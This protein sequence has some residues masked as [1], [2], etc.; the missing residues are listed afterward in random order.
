[1]I[2]TD[3]RLQRSNTALSS[4]ESSATFPP[5]CPIAHGDAELSALFCTL[6]RL[7]GRPRRANA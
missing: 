1:M 6:D 5:V 2:F 4:L 7:S 3:V